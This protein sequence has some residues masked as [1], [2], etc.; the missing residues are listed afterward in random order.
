M[1]RD[2]SP[3]VTPAPVGTRGWRRLVLAL[4]LPAGLAVAGA[5]AWAVTG[6]GADEMAAT[7]GPQADI[8]RPAPVVMAAARPPVE[9]VVLPG[10]VHPPRAPHL[11]F[12]VRGPLDGLL[13][14]EG[15]EVE[16]GA[17]LAR[18]DAR[19]FQLAVD[20]VSALLQAAE[21]ARD[22]AERDHARR[23][24]LFATETAS[25]AGL[26]AAL[27]A[28]DRAAAEVR[29]LQSRLRAAQAA[30]D[31]TALRAPFAGRV[32]RLLVE[33]HD[34]VEAG[35]PVL[36]LHD[37]GGTDVTVDLPESLAAR[38][39][40]IRSVSVTLAHRSD[41]PVAAVLRE[42]AAVSEAPTGLYRATVGLADP[43][44]APLAGLSATVRFEVSSTDQTGQE[45]MVPTSAV[46]AG[47][48]GD[49]SVWLVEAGTV[50]TAEAGND[51]A[52]VRR[53]TV[54]V[55]GIMGAWSRL[56][57]GLA[58]GDEVVTAGVHFLREGQK[59]R[60]LRGDV[61]AR[62]NGAHR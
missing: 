3:A 9:T 11:A 12:R 13:V 60:P 23:A 24:R 56:S 15:D 33:P 18:I 48:R 4:G 61:P 35:R 38:R 37:T 30:L 43:A 28:R 44:G 16:A 42:I 7:L 49:D 5:A 54:S 8:V 53:Q 19:D 55:V 6:G 27:A 17:V 25:R 10:V 57:G 1:T 14:G 59:I 20:D 62:A 32:A 45:V 2:P 40:A 51:V 22:L 41:R 39:K 47:P 36:V 58:P 26:D 34:Y 46:H 31:D 29:A 52:L 50:E 21:A